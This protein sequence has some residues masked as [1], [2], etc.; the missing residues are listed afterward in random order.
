MNLQW[1]F[2]TNLK[3][4]R[5]KLGISQMALS[6][7]CD[8]SSNYIGQIEMG[9]RIPSFDKIEEIAAA[10]KIPA[11]LLFIEE[12]PEETKKPKIETRDYLRRMPAHVKKEI[13]SRLVTDLKAGIAAYLDSGKY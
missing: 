11:G 10:L 4:Y 1:T 9:R 5:K 12:S 7:M 2:I 13:F 8:T 6:N 3:N